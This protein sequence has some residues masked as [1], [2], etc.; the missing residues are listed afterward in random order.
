MYW[1]V[2]TVTSS[3]L[4]V[5][6]NHGLKLNEYRIIPMTAALAGNMMFRS[7]TTMRR[8]WRGGSGAGISNSAGS[9]FSHWTWLGFINSLTMKNDLAQQFQHAL[10]NF[11]NRP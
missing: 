4:E 1:T 5:W 3:V 8:N 6:P 9:R 11:F 2:S 7:M 10:R